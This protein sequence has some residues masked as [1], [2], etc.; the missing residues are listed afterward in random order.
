MVQIQAKKILC[1]EKKNIA[2]S[3]SYCKQSSVMHPIDEFK[4]MIWP[5]ALIDEFTNFNPCNW[6]VWK[7]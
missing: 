7:I 2:P 3:L 4:F 6:I 5:D 1:G